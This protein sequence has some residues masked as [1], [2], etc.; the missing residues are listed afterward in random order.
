MV[1]SFA[2]FA[3]VVLLVVAAASAPARPPQEANQPAAGGKKAGAES[4]TKAKK[5]YD[6]DC[7]LCHGATGDGKSDLAKDMSLNLMDWT[8]PKTLSGMS[9]QALIEVIRKG[10]G[11]MPPEDATRAN[12]DEIKSL[13]SLIRK[14]A[15]D[16]PAPAAAPSAEPTTSPT[17]APA[18]APAQSPSR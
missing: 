6:L 12:N 1:K 7:A 13:V 14:F 9:D 15:K 4:M 2:L 3:A 17:P 8:D 16:G 5:V 18:A 10:K 11:K